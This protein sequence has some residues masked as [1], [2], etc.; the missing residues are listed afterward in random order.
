CRCLKNEKT[1][2]LIKIRKRFF[3][4]F[5]LLGVGHPRWSDFEKSALKSP[6]T[7]MNT[8][9]NRGDIYFVTPSWEGVTKL[10]SVGLIS[11]GINLL[12]KIKR[13]TQQKKNHRLRRDTFDC[14][15]NPFF[16]FF[17]F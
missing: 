16:C 1:A 15:C 7:R 8:E 6:K 2:S 10:L 9:K 17:A 14:F 11:F 4:F 3:A 12:N 5:A 13:N